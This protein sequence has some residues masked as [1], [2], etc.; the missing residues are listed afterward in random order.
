MSSWQIVLLEP[1]RLILSQIGQ[2][3][4]NLLLVIIILV[5][6]LVVSK[7]IK[8]VVVKVLRALKL[9]EIS[10]KIE[11]ESILAKGGI[12][13]SLSELI[14]VVFYWLSMLVFLMVAINALGLTVAAEL[15]N[16]VVLFMP[17]VI[18]AIFILVCG[19]FAATVLRNIVHAAASN[20]G[21]AQVGFLSK[22]VEIVV[23][24]FVIFVALEQLNIGVR[25]TELTVS[26]ILGS[27]GL[28]L[29]LSFGLGCK[30]IAGKFIA[31][32]VEKMKSKK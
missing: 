25:I 29:A 20:A 28:A 1:A 2:F 13:Y 5:V 10:E 21:I 14:G 12:A 15:L 9:D 11:F 32:L 3:L 17:H 18:A 31:E 23:M 22:V 6:G 19:M 24:A 27:I 26:I 4:M 7:L 16:R 30:D 8:T